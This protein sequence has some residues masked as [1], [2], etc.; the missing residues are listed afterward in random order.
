MGA[1]RMRVQSL[2][3]SMNVY[4]FSSSKFLFH[5]ILTDGLEWCELLV[6]YC[7]VFVKCLDTHSDDTHSLKRIHW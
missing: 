1:V 4:F 2:N 6:D 3:A 5:K 7:D